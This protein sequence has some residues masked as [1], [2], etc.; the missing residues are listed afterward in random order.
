MV[1]T[2]LVVS[3]PTPVLSLPSFESV[4]CASVSVGFSVDTLVVWTGETVGLDLAARNDSSRTVTAMDIKIQQLTSWG[5]Q[6]HKDHRKRTL[7]SILV[8][9]SSLGALQWPAEGGTRRGQ[10]LASVAEAAREDLERQIAAGTGTRY[11]L[12]IPRNALLTVQTDLVQ[13]QHFLVVKL[14]IKGANSPPDISTG[15]QVQTPPVSA[16]GAQPEADSL[17]P[18]LQ[19]AMP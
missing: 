4:T 10:S 1:P 9:D 18:P 11:E 8:R 3:E 2:F 16:A 13:V 7:S 17:L 6:G 19:E 14:Q 5:A 12:F 15:L